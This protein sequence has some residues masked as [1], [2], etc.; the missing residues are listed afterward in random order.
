[1]VFGVKTGEGKILSVGVNEFIMFVS[2]VKPRRSDKNAR[3]LRPVL[4]AVRIRK[5]ETIFH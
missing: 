5:I 1:M 4:V 2:D 3:S